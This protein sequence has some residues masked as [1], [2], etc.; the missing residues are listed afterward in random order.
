MKIWHR[1][2][3][4]LLVGWSAA[5]A[6]QGPAARD[7]RAWRFSDRVY[8]KNN[9]TP[10][11]LDYSQKILRK[12]V[13]SAG[14][15]DP[16]NRACWGLE[17][18]HADAGRVRYVVN[19]AATPADTLWYALTTPDYWMPGEC[20]Y[21]GVVGEAV[22]PDSVRIYFTDGSSLSVKREGKRK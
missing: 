13:M 2:L 1:A 11:P 19:T 6:K 5:E 14:H 22:V 12:I 20:C 17:G 7:E 16:V 21:V 15:S 9:R 18:P 10:M 3:L 8:A 4:V